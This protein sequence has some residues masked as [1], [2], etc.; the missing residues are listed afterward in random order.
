MYLKSVMI[1]N[2][3]SLKEIEVELDP[4][5]V[6]IGE[7]NTGKTSFMDA[8]RI[9]LSRVNGRYAFEDYDYYMDEKIMSPKESDGIEI[10]LIFQERIFEEWEGLSWICWV[11]QS[12]I[13]EMKRNWVPS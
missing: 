2:F 4:Q 7:N 9:A 8:V 6:L 3:R 12:N 5:T 10:I 11:K 13:L 1:K